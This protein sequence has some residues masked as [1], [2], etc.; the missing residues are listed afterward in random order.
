MRA[1]GLGSEVAWPGESHGCGMHHVC[2]CACFSI[3]INSCFCQPRSSNDAMLCSLCSCCRAGGGCQREYGTR[4]LQHVRCYACVQRGHLSC[5]AAPA[6]PAKLSCHNCGQG[7]HTAAECSRE[8]PQ[9]IRGEQMGGRSFA[10]RG[11]GGGYYSG[12]GGRGRE[13]PSGGYGGSGYSSRQN[14]SAYTEQQERYGGRRYSAPAAG[15]SRRYEQQ[16][17]DDNYGQQYSSGGKRPRW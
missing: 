4:D 5:A 7:G 3:R 11:G 9:V 1:S 16:Y 10:D 2:V 17:D 8:V 6:E 12:G 13:Q 14:H 15:G